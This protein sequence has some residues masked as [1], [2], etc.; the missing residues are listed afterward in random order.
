MSYAYVGKHFK[1]IGEYS[2]FLD[3]VPFVKWAREKPLPPLQRPLNAPYTLP[4]AEVLHHSAIPTIQQWQGLTTMRG[5]VAYYQSLGWSAA[6]H[7]YL[8]V[9]SPNPANDGIWLMTPHT[10]MGIHAFDYNEWALALEVVGNFDLVFYSDALAEMV[11]SLLALWCDR[12]GIDPMRD[13]RRIR[14]HGQAN[15]DFGHAGKT[16][17]GNTVVARMPQ[18]RAAVAERRTIAAPVVTVAGLYR[19]PP[20][21]VATVRSAPRRSPT[22]IVQTLTWLSKPVEIVGSEQGESVQGSAVWYK[23]AQGYYIHSSGITQLR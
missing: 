10:E 7:A 19:V 1:T 15:R 6:P 2:A 3:T 21:R 17:P 16:C 5:M 20:L 18:I 11:Y 9:G 4:T 8:A 13:D 22:N 12:C 23:T 14:P